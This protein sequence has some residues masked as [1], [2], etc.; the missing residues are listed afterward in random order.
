MMA[1]YL[2]RA[3]FA[4]KTLTQLRHVLDSWE[5]VPMHPFGK[6]LDYSLLNARYEPSS[7]LGVWVEEDYCTPPLA[8]EREAVLDHYFHI[9]EIENVNL[10]DGW[11]RVAHLPSLWTPVLGLPRREG[12]KPLTRKGMPHQ[13]LTQKPPTNLYNLSA[14]KSSACPTWRKI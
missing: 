13:Q 9:E 5:I 10:L 11:R 4:W 8:M 6:A 7:G 14:E 1:H 2:V 3:G 12:E